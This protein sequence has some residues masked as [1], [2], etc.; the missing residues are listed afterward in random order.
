MMIVEM[1]A[2]QYPIYLACL[3]WFELIL[4]NSIVLFDLIILLHTNNLSVM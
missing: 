2:K 4:Y 1:D 3:I